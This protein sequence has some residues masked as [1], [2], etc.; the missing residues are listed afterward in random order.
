MLSKKIESLLGERGVAL[1]ILVNKGVISEADVTGYFKKVKQ[2][3]RLEYE[4][5]LL[6]LGL[7]SS[8]ERDLLKAISFATKS[9]YI[10]APG[11]G[12]PSYQPF[13]ELYRRVKTGKLDQGNL[14]ALLRIFD[15]PSRYGE[16]T[17]LL[18]NKN[19][20]IWKRLAKSAEKLRNKEDFDEDFSPYR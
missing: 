3:E 9:Y 13:V 6:S 11:A 19:K 18:K 20:E 15:E 5:R 1:D 17:V 16:K 10:G 14:E 8:E 12:S 2:K 7:F 4:K